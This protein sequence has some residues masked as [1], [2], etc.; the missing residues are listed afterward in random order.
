MNRE[1][2]NFKVRGSAHA[3]RFCFPTLRVAGFTYVE[4]LSVVAIVSI[5][6]AIALPAYIDYVIRAEVSEGLIFLGD[7]KASVNDFQARW[8][9]MPVDNAEAGLQAPE[10]M[11]GNIL[12]RFDVIDGTL[13]ASL[14]VGK[15]HLRQPLERTLTFRPWLNNK[16]S[17]SPIIWSCGVA[18]PDLPVG[19]ATSGKL[20]ANPLEDKYLP[21]N[22]RQ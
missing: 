18:D 10:Q 1:A 17:G 3:R 19:Y 20:A 22:C 2:M 16:V 5:L 4:L 14:Q 13:V 11:S 15:G 12:R 6:A 9:R 7:A 21:S 8:G